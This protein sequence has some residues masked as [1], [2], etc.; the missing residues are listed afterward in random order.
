MNGVPRL[1]C[2][3]L[4]LIVGAWPSPAVVAWIDS[5]QKITTAAKSAAPTETQAPSPP[6][7]PLQP[8]P[9]SL[10]EVAREARAE[11]H[12][13][14][15]AAMVFTNDNLP[16]AGGVSVVGETATVTSEGNA[17]SSEA[18]AH[19]SKG[20]SYWRARFGALRTKLRQNEAALEI[21]QRELGEL[22]VQYY[23]DPQEALRQG[24]TRSDINNKTA[25]IDDANKN[26]ADIQQQLSDLED[27]LRKSGGDPG[28]ARE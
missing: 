25:A 21:M 26:I 23:A 6:Q 5:P 11:R 13:A 8:R 4:S 9:V 22:N 3:L 15:K 16:T 2:I 10:A 19:E 18:N 1:R 20:E 27:E 24:Y 7:E 14:P 28:W 12:N 17:A